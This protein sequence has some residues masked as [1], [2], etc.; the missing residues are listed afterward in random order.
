MR[1]LLAAKRIVAAVGD[2]CAACQWRPAMTGLGNWTSDNLMA[3]DPGSL[4]CRTG[5]RQRL[6]SRQFN[7]WTESSVGREQLKILA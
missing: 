7:V 3:S 5:T 4:Q 1:R 6:A 2:L